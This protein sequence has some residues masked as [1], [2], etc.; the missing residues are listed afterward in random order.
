MPISDAPSY[1]EPYLSAARKYGA[2]FGSLLW[3]SP[4]TQAVRFEALLKLVDVNGQS[5]LDVGCGRADL[6]QYLFRTDRFPASYIGLEAVDA[7]ALAAE[8]KCLAG[9]RIIRG[10][11][12]LNPRLL[13]QDADVLLI[14]GALN[15]MEPGCFY[16]CLGTAIAA[17]KKAVVFNFLSSPYLAGASHLTWHRVEDV[18]S[19]CREFSSKVSCRSD[20]LP[21]DATVCVKKDL[22]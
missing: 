1:L 2:G 6:L 7:L 16:Q 13:Q 9:C 11:F 12:V 8:A 3:A 10:D 18:L 20:Y 4:R 19:F 22:L 5:V 21:G 17:A 15:T 14:S